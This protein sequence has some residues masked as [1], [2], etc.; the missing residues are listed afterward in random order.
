MRAFRP[1]GR[2]VTAAFLAAAPAQAQLLAVWRSCLGDDQSGALSRSTAAPGSSSRELEI[3]DHLAVA[4]FNRGVVFQDQGA[5]DRRDRLRSR[6]PARSQPGRGLRRPRRGALRQGG[7]RRTPSRLRRGRPAEAGRR[8]RL[9][10][11]RGGPR[12][13]GRRRRRAGRLR[14]GGRPRAAV[15]RAVGP[16]RPGLR[17]PGRRRTGARRLRPPRCSCGP[18]MRRR[19]PIAPRCYARRGDSPARWRGL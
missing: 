7:L 16:A 3:P 11:P 15:R 12:G 10:R 17:A 8:R 1:C 14:P 13:A 6:R 18:A 9:A 19:W 4:F 5:L 2:P